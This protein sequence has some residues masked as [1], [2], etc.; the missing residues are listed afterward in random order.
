MPD[1]FSGKPRNDNTRSWMAMCRESIAP[2]AGCGPAFAELFQD[3]YPEFI[4]WMKDSQLP[5]KCPV[6]EA[7]V[8]GPL[9][10][11]SFSWTGYRDNTEEEAIKAKGGSVVAFSTKKTNVLFVRA[12]GKASSKADKAE[13]AGVTVAE[14]TQYMK[15][16]G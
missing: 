4:S 11:L 12:E 5:W 1:L 7:K 6:D 14:F 15:R 16:K 8:E 2:V 10:G 13:A 3:G 9:S